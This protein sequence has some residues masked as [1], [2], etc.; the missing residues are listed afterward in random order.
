MNKFFLMIA[1]VVG[2]DAIRVKKTN[3]NGAGAVATTGSWSLGS[4][5]ALEPTPTGNDW[6]QGSGTSTVRCEGNMFNCFG[7]FADS[8]PCCN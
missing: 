3:V 8:D 4:H 1:A 2:S 5:G 6:P 7:P